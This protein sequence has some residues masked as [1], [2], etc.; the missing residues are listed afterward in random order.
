MNENL[1]AKAKLL[2]ERNTNSPLFLNIAN[3]CL[4]KNEV[5]NAILILEEGLKVFP[6]HP[7]A[8]ILLGR[9]NHMLGNVDAADSF[10][11]QASELL[12]SGR[13]Y[14]HYK[15]ELKLPD[16]LVSP[17]DSSRGNI[18]INSFVNDDNLKNEPKIVA[19]SQSID[20][21]LAQL[22]D[23]VMKAKIERNENFSIPETNQET[24]LPDKSKLA[25]E[26]LA[27]IYLTQGEK[28]EAIKIYEVLINRNPEK[29][30]Y[31]LGKISEINSQ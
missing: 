29:K 19:S 1:N 6:E 18:F 9:A 12:D 10:I 14:T 22:A 11:K 23:E 20:E 15:K 25:S 5:Q 21:K 24:I 8:F 28:N 2:F 7:L 16:K 31:Y 17:F 30:E 4:K 26:T 13:T 3:T 27:N